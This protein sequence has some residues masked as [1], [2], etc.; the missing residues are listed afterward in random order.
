MRLIRRLGESDC[1]RERWTCQAIAWGFGETEL[2]REASA[3]CGHLSLARRMCAL[4]KNRELR[5]NVSELSP[6][7]IA[8]RAN[9]CDA[10]S[11]FALRK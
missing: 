9:A 5:A 6:D 1:R 3:L 8:D 4:G 11:R 10:K 7:L 2:A